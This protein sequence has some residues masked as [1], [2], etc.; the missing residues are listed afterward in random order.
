MT[1][2][3]GLAPHVKV[4]PPDTLVKMVGKYAQP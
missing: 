2:V 3:N 1:V 4:V